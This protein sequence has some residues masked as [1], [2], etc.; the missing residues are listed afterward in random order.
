LSWSRSVAVNRPQPARAAKAF[1]GIILLALFTLLLS[2]WQ[3][4]AGGFFDGFEAYAPGGLDSTDS[5]G[6]NAGPNGGTNPWFGGGT[7]PNLRVASAENGVTPHSGTNMV[8]GCYNCIYHDDVQ[9]F[10]LSFRCAT[11]GVYYGNI[12]LDWWFYD[13]LG[14]GG[15]GSYVDYV[16]L[17]NYANVPPDMDY[18]DLSLMPSFNSQSMSLGADDL[19]YNTNIDATVYQARIVGATD[20]VNEQGWLNLTN[21]PRSKGW[22]HA[23]IVIGVPNGADTPASFYIDN[24][25]TP[26]LT[27]RT[28]NA[29]GFNLLEIDG[30]WGNTSGY[31]DDFAFQDDA[32]APTFATGPTNVT[33][34]AGAKASFSVGG[35]SGSPAPSC[36]WQKDG[37]PLSNG[38]RISGANTNTLAI[39]NVVA[40][41][42]G[43]YSCLVSNIAGVVAASAT[44]TVVVP[45]TIDSQIP[46]GGAFPAGSGGTVNLSVTAH[47]T[48]PINYL[49]NENG[50]PLSDGGHVSGVT[51]STLT[52]TG[53]DA[54]DEGT[55]SCH[56]SNAD[57]A[58]D[59]QPVI[60]S[61]ASG[62]TIVVQPTAQAI[63]LGSN[64][65]FTVTAAGASLVYQW[66]KGTTAL[67]NGGRI[68]GA[69]SSALTIGAVIDTDAS[70]YSCLITNSG[71]TTNTASV[72]LTVVD[73]PVI[74]TQPLGQVANIGNTVGFHVTASGT[75][76]T[77][78]WKLNG[79][80][81]TNGGDFSGT[82]TPDLSVHVT[83]LA[84]VGVYTVTVSNLA[85]SVTSA[86]AALRVNQTT[87]NFFD[88]FETY[89]LISPIGKG[90]GGT[91]LDNNY[92]N[93]T[94]NSPDTCPW[95]G[96]SPPN[97][98]TYA[99][100]QLLE[101]INQTSILAYS[102]SQMV[103]GVYD[104][105]SGSGDND[106]TFLNLAYRFN[107]GQLYYGD[108]MLDYYFYDPGTPD[109]GDQ[110]SLANFSSGI[111][112]T[113][114][115]IGGNIPSGPI[116][117][118]FVGAWP[119]LN[120]N[121][122]QAGV[123]GAADGTTG[124]ISKN[125]SG[126]T[127]YFNTT[128]PRSQGW[129][130]ARIVV[131]PADPGTYVANVQFFV[132]DMTNAAFSHA[133]PAGHVG[134]NSI[135]LLACTVFTA[136]P[137]PTTETA[138]CFD[139]LT[140]QAVNDP[141]IVQQPVSL[142]NDFGT[143]ATFTVV[144]MAANYQWQRNGGDLTGATN[145]TLTLNSVGLGDAGSYTCVLTGANGSITSSAATLTITGSPLYI[146][147]IVPS[148]A[149][150]IIS[151][152]ANASDP[153]SA[154]KVLN[155]AVVTGVTNLD[156]AAV[157]TGG[158]GV[159]QATVP[160][161][162]PSQFYR[163]QR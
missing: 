141:Y 113:S 134:F 114:D 32:T 53:V 20:A 72:A 5:A 31:F 68:S 118:L 65:T 82:T 130:H 162:G 40:G 35:V 26:A 73:P 157:I 135:H 116:Q 21:A 54:T 93:G 74:T 76:P 43:I 161:S 2:A 83:T 27:H 8:R 144:G 70:S 119:N 55:Y 98:C 90:R 59:S 58:T 23:R 133:L 57:G 128:V 143:P 11:G 3:A 115:S 163:I 49:W 66:S 42:E 44:L 105:V 28:V 123:M 79:A 127:K 51:N 17:G 91:P 25:L 16:A 122:Y 149:N 71:G 150:F 52:L 92:L 151:F 4:R 88:D 126:T 124:R 50:T 106:E 102:G 61:L 87:A 156:A 13:P 158:G 67:G 100:G 125:I 154:F 24:M 104:S 15:G 96:P 120:T 10:N 136:F 137:L 69:T 89:S 84:D 85:A 148:G 78:R 45:P 18:A 131:G 160:A 112:P 1:G 6:P 153:A 47:A 145:A 46:A 140:F 152:V 132:D 80:A 97:F 147:S 14:A 117:N 62:P 139:T 37:T 60:L 101:P 81:L 22:H 109:Y 159:Y 29:D 64:A 129:H 36:F 99:S 110:L 108:I 30:D 111:P 142:T 34:L 155:G 56:L 38:G 7:L 9:W 39:T 12:A 63:V 19:F 121:V 138:G 77:Y 95:W 94:V 103:G 86:G 107:A 41:D 33:L 75:S 48:H 146:T